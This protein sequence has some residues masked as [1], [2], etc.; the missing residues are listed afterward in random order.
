M[1]CQD[2][3][4]WSTWIFVVIVLN[5]LRNL[6]IIPLENLSHWRPKPILATVLF[7]PNDLVE[8]QL[9]QKEGVVK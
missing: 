2:R 9:N 5:I 8:L 3:V 7:K 4:T 6:P 1:A